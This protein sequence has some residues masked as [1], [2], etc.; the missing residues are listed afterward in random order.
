MCP[1][2]DKD[3]LLRVGGRLREADISNEERQ[4]LILPNSCHVSTLIVRHYHA[5]VQ[6]QGQV[7]THGSVRS[8]GY[9]IIG[10]K[11]MV[12]SVIDK[13][14]K[15]KKLRGQRQTQ[16][17]AN[18][19]ADRVNP[20]PPFSYV[21]LD[22]FGPWQICAR[23]TRGG[24]AHAKRWAVL[25]TCMETRAIQ[26]EVIEAM[27]TSSFI[28]ALRRFLALRGP[29]I[30][31]RSDCGSNFVGARNELEGVLKPSDISA[32]QRYLLKEGCEWI[33]NPPHASHA[34]G[35]WER[36][37]GVT[38]R[39][40]EAM[41]SEVP[42]KHLTHEVL[43]TLMAEVAAIV[44]ARPLVPVSSDPEVP[45]ILPPATLLTQKPQ[46]LKPPSGDFNVRDLYSAQWRRVQH[47]ANIFWYRWRKEYL[48]TL[49]GRRKWQDTTRNLKQDDLVLLCSKD[50]PRNDWPLARITSAQADRDGKVRKVDLVT[51]KDGC[52]KYFRRPITETILLN[53]DEKHKEQ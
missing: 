19:P 2:I 26:I 48:Q 46:Q 53:A 20:A 22:V 38:R 33:F 28:N 34:G 32:A 44:N 36:M 15:C 31:L 1:I 9:W 6:H 27:D 13:C 4:P 25:F 12:N 23:C 35:A 41:L 47:L 17:M 5:K 49:Q 43:T 21:G 14:L 24:L 29:V 10:G 8:H 18:L 3:G 40:L 7:F 16:K 45:E 11:R 52:R 30:Q 51:T 42:S 50:A 39:I 37:I